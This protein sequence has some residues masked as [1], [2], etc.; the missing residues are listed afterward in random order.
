MGLV[1]AW[2]IF[3]TLHILRCI[4][5]CSLLGGG[6]EKYSTGCASTPLYP[7]VPIYVPLL[8][9][10]E[11]VGPGQVDCLLYSGTWNEG[12]AK[13]VNVSLSTKHSLSE[14]YVSLWGL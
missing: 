7:F 12:F 3:L 8:G 1:G 6:H 2:D 13:E 11:G 14:N 5:L 4:A 9:D 10:A